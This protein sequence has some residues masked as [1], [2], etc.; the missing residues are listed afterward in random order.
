M[1]DTRDQ[2]LSILYVDDEPGLLEIGKIFLE[3][4]GKFTVTTAGGP[5]E[6]IK[7]LKEQP[8]DAIISDYQMPGMDGIA[9]LK[10]LRL[11]GDTTPFI[12]FTGKGREE[13]VIEALNE[14]ADFYLQKEGDPK[15]QF[16]ELANKIRYAVTRKQAEKALLLKNEELAASEE[17]MRSQLEEIISIRDLLDESNEYLENLITYANAPIIV[18]DRDLRITKFNNAFG[19]LTGIPP[20]QAIGSHIEVL[21]PSE[22]RDVAMDMIQRAMAGETWDVVEIPIQHRSGEVRSVLWNSANIRG[23]DGKTII[24]T[25]AQGQDITDRK[26]AELAATE[27]ELRHNIEELEAQ[28]L[29][30][31]KKTKEIADIIEFLPDATF[32]IDADKTVIA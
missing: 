25:I 21:F 5:D 13:V 9:F 2:P 20:E 18:W 4:D 15:A 28:E 10:H 8:F 1:V 32:V 30:I 31:R 7:L 6:G 23:S 22:R 19:R 26:K 24:A 17:E 27:E 3:K 12:I 14:G 16:A 29:A 11:A